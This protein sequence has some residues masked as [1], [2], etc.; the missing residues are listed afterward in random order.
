MFANAITRKLTKDVING[1]NCRGENRL[2]E[3]AAT[4]ADPLRAITRVDKCRAAGL[5]DCTTAYCRAKFPQPRQWPGNFIADFARA[6][7]E[8]DLTYAWW[9]DA[10]EA[11][12]RRE[13]TWAPGMKVVCERFELV[14][15]F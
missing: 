14:E 13:G 11:Y 2:P 6:E 5:I 10:H 15:I 12:Y 4:H 7:G 8:G 1:I 9:R 3:Q